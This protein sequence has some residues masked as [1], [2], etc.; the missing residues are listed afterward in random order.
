MAVQRQT[1]WHKEK[2]AWQNTACCQ[3]DNEERSKKFRLQRTL[4]TCSDHYVDRMTVCDCR[5]KVLG[6]E[7]ASPL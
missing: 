7:Y 5:K 6:Q 2:R 1:E 4:V 3:F